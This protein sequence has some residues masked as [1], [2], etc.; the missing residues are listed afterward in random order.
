MA[1]TLQHIKRNKTHEQP[2]FFSSGA[3]RAPFSLWLYVLIVFGLSW[4]FQIIGAIWARDLPQL[5]A[6]NGTA[7]LMVTVGTYIAGKYVFRDGF[8]GAGWR[9]GK[10]RHYVWVGVLVAVLWLVP[11]GISLA[12][13]R[14]VLPRGLTTE[15]VVWVFILLF[16]TL[17][18]GFGEEFG[19]RGYMLPRLGRRLSPRRAVF[20]HAVIWWAWHLPIVVGAAVKSGLAGAAQIAAPVWI[21]VTFVVAVTLALNAVGGVLHGVIFA[22]IWVRSQSLA[23][24]TVYHAAYDGVRDSLSITLGLGPMTGLWAN[25]VLV[26]L[27]IFLLVKGDWRGLKE[28]EA[29]VAAPEAAPAVA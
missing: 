2:R 16:V 8:A 10:A 1:G 17:L 4:P 27:G 9:W 3:W 23:V 14:A 25:V 6:L 7:M 15:Q 21:T 18:P 11:A 5:Y 26:A 22:Y 29:A 20:V 28:P 19:W 12:F 24:A 13:G